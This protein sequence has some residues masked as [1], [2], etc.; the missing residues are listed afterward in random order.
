MSVLFFE[1]LLKK[2]QI[3]EFYECDLSEIRVNVFSVY[4][5]SIQFFWLGL[6]NNKII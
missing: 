3:S 2:R 5:L 6:K 1:Q 4:D